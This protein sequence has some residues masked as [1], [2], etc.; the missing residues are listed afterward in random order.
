MFIAHFVSWK[1]RVRKYRKSMAKRSRM[2]KT[3]VREL[4]DTVLTKFLIENT[5][6]P[7]IT[8][9]ELRSPGDMDSALWGFLPDDILES[10]LAMLPFDDLIT[11]RYVC[12]QWN[13]VIMSRGLC[14]PDQNPQLLCNMSGSFTIYNQT[15]AKWTQRSLNFVENHKDLYLAT[16]D[17]GLLCFQNRE[18]GALIV[19]NPA[20]KSSR[21]LPPPLF[22]VSMDAETG[23]GR[24]LDMINIGHVRFLAARSRSWNARMTKCV[25]GMSYDRE[26]QNY[27]VVVAS[28]LTKRPQTQV[29]DFLTNSW[30][31]GA[32][33]PTVT[34]FRRSPVAC[35]NCL[36]CVVRGLR[37][38]NS[39]DAWDWSVIKYDME[40]DAWCDIPMPRHRIRDNI[41][42]IELAEHRGH[43]RM[44]LRLVHS[45]IFHCWELNAD[46]A[47]WFPLTDLQNEVNERLA[48]TRY[49]DL[50]LAGGD[51]IYL[52][53]VNVWDDEILR[54]VQCYDLTTK[55][56]SR[57]PH[58][59]PLN[60]YDCQMCLFQPS[61]T[62]AA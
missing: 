36:F 43:V 27:R 53:L 42:A 35:N 23:E 58:I 2:L 6:S 60:S 32:D 24:S 9:E 21:E 8:D 20:C 61:L 1:E 18:T 57:L 45:L 12:K 44:F 47:S 59:V 38:G 48:G 51:L 25:V 17:G 50:C 29:Y 62:V 15:K 4:G 30:Y 39:E 49:W 34:W 37:D 41:F 26:Q 56:W 13:S 54:F 5:A 55:L 31:I 11:M 40:L 14:P 7:A 52:M 33:P 19:C 22:E 46:S 28:M 16:S 10:V 3:R